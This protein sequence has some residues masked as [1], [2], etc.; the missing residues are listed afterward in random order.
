MKKLLYV[1]HRYA[2]FPGGSE[3][4]V[5]DLAEESVRQG[6]D[7]TVF[8]GT[9]KGDLNGVKLT[10]DP[11]IIEQDFDLIIIHGGDVYIQNYV[12]ERIRFLKSPVLYL[13]ILPSE[14]AVCLQALKDASYIGCSTLEDWA[15]VE[16]YGV[17]N[18]SIEINVSIDI[19]KSAG[20]LG[21]KKKY[22]IQTEK[23]FLSSGGFWQHKGMEKLKE[24]FNRLPIKDTTLVLTG[25]QNWNMA[26]K[27]TSH[28]KCLLLEEKQDVLDAM[29][30]TD[31]Y[32]MN[33]YNEGFGLVLLEAMYN[34]APWA[35]RNIAGAR[36]MSAF[37]NTYNSD[38]ELMKIMMNYKKDQYVL[39]QAKSH[40]IEKHSNRSVVE[41]ILKLGE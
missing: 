27:E 5:R 12:L 14:S 16:K 23:M 29:K 34:K 2:P 33:S 32:I 36:L 9:H 19:Q 17:K 24:L 31:L 21:F 6:C 4:H 39:E 18:K 37:G 41:K 28:I 20:I 26:P 10:S 40:V 1:V 13:L 11:S 35:A 30:E 7:V 3:N 22:N 25:Y 15:H 8:A 38:S